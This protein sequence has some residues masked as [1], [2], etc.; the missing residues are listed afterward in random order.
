LPTDRWRFGAG[1][2]Q[3]H[4]KKLAR[5]RPVDELGP[6]RTARSHQGTSNSQIATPQ[7]ATNQKSESQNS[8]SSRFIVGCRLMLVW[9]RNGVR[10][11]A[12]ALPEL[13]RPVLLLR[14]NDLGFAATRCP[15]PSKAFA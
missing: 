9:P 14:A 11:E 7:E 8:A 12:D 2:R 6:V 15:C 5:P 1:W 13:L 3:I 10:D 4:A